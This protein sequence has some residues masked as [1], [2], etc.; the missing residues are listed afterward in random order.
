V[1]KVPDGGGRNAG[2]ALR[3]LQR[4]RL[5]P[6]PVRLE[7][8]RCTIDKLAIR[9]TGRDDLPP[10]RV[11]Q[12]DIAADIEA[13]PRVGP[14][15]RAR[16]TWVDRVEASPLPDAAEEVVE[17]DRMRLP[18]IAAPEDDQIGVLDLTV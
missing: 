14:L 8:A 16:P 17:E 9:E 11:R 3:V 2:L 13:E 4:V 10:N 12:G 1:G 5:D 7:S 6:F 15:G 18:G